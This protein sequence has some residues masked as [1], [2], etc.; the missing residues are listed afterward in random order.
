MLLM[1]CK[2]QKDRDHTNL[3]ALCL[4]GTALTVGSYK[5]EERVPSVGRI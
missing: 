5:L 1:M 3:S 4:Q 2:P